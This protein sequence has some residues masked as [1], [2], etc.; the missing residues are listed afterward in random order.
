MFVKSI[1][2]VIRNETPTKSA[3]NFVFRSQVF[4]V[5]VFLN[6]NNKWATIELTVFFPVADTHYQ[7]AKS[8]SIAYEATGVDRSIF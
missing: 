6:I 2:K 1:K 3:Y 7:M 8:V 5:I 4:I